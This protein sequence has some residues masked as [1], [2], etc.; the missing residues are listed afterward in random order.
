MQTVQDPSNTQPEIDVYARQSPRF[1]QWVKI[2]RESVI[3]T[4][5]PSKGFPIGS[6]GAFNLCVMIGNE[7]RYGTHFRG[8]VAIDQYGT[9][10][11]EAALKE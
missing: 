9:T 3:K 7:P 2:Q 11:A 6:T 5:N 1:P 8:S 10:R 4:V